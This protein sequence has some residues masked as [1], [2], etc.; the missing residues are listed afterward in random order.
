MNAMSSVMRMA[1]RFLAVSAE[2]APS[3]CHRRVWV[4]FLSNWG[5]KVVQVEEHSTL[6]VR[7]VLLEQCSTCL[8]HFV[9]CASPSLSSEGASPL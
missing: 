8:K 2:R 3:Y 5:K 4:E 6:H 1:P 9:S 7:A